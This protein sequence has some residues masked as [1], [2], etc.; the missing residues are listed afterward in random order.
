MRNKVC[1]L[2]IKRPSLLPDEEAIK[3]AQICYNLKCLHVRVFPNL[4]Q[5]NF[6]NKLY[7]SAS[8]VEWRAI[9][10]C[11]KSIFEQGPDFQQLQQQQ[12]QQQQQVGNINTLIEGGGGSEEI[13]IRKLNCRIMHN[14]FFKSSLI[15][16]TIHKQSPL[17][18]L[19]T[20]FLGTRDTSLRRIKI[21]GTLSSLF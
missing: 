5:V 8:W 15:R 13:W 14:Y 6:L 16:E 10:T 9:L 19:G 18:V 3:I 1:F 21:I 12:Q 11:T 20:F 7:N 17:L 2:L 4:T